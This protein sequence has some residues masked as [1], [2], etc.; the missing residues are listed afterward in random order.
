MTITV[1][2]NTVYLLL[3]AVVLGWWLGS[4]PA[5]PI[6]PHPVPDR[7]VLTAFVGTPG[8]RPCRGVVM[9]FNFRGIVPFLIAV[10]AALG[11]VC[12]ALAVGAW[13]IGWWVWEH[14]QWIP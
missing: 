5:S 6:N 12:A 14:V 2:R 13:R 8:D 10:G 4:S 11:V 7:P 3:A 9:Y 1:S